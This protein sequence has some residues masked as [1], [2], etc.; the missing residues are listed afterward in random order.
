MFKVG[1]KVCSMIPNDPNFLRTAEVLQERYD[2]QHGEV[3]LISYPEGIQSWIRAY[4]E[5]FARVVNE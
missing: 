1:D 4:E 3:V 2:P 5:K